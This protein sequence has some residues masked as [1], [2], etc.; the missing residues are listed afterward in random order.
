MK[1]RNNHFIK[2]IAHEVLADIETPEFAM[3]RFPDLFSSLPHIRNHG[4][5][6]TCGPR[7][8]KIQ[9]GKTT[10]HL[11]NSKMGCPAPDLHA[12]YGKLKPQE[13]ILSLNYPGLCCRMFTKSQA[14]NFLIRY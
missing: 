1:I 6:N 8:V 13:I 3:F 2:F 9:L 12:P 10:P 11:P 4:V 7:V 14:T 5:S